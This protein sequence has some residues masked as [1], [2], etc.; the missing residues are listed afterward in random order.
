MT[1]LLA[2][3]LPAVMGFAAALLAGQAADAALPRI[4]QTTDPVFPAGPEASG[5]SYGEA[6]ILINVNARG[7]LIDYLVTAYTRKP[8][9]DAALA[10]LRTWSFEPADEN[11]QT[12]G[13]MR[14]I[15]VVFRSSG[16][17]IVIDN[18]EHPAGKLSLL[19][20]RDE[21]LTYH[22][23]AL[24]DLDHV[25]VPRSAAR[26]AGHSRI[27]VVIAFYIDEQGRVRLP[28][29]QEGADDPFAQAASVAVAGWRFAPPMRK[30]RPVLVRATQAFA[31][32]R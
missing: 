23:Y 16:G 17:S 21:V 14:E 8:F 18:I 1:F 5:F 25:P 20:D 31:P 12:V 32:G 2:S 15:E 3:R 24:G 6:R 10:A 29:I 9:A 13:W 7:K 11:G 28:T 22:A 30:G 19:N 4:V 26:P 27:R